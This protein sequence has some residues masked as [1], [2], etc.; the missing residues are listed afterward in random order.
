MLSLEFSGLVPVNTPT[1]KA[2]WLDHGDDAPSCQLLPFGAREGVLGTPFFSFL[3]KQDSPIPPVC[4]DSLCLCGNQ[5]TR[6][7][8]KDSG[9][10]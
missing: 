4:T 9:R 10:G 8:Q 3:I 5:L 1:G 6:S 2:A 7:F